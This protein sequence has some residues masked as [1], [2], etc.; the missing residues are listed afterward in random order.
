[1]KTDRVYLDW[2]AT[3]PLRPAARAA[4]IASL[5]VTGNPSSVHAEGRSARRLVEQARAELAALVGGTASG[6]VFTSGGSEANAIALTPGLEG[7]PGHRRG[8]LL[9]SAVEHPSVLSGGRFAHTE[10]EVVGV[11]DQGRLSLAELARRLETHF[12]SGIRPLVSL[13]LANNETGVIQPIAETAELVHGCDGLLH[14]DAVQ[15]A[16][17]FN[18]D[19][20][21]LGADLITLSGHKLGGPQGVGALIRRSEAIHLSDPLIRGGGQERGWRAGT[22]NVAAIAGFGAGAAMARQ[23]LAT[24]PTRLAT[25]R[26]RLEAGLAVI[27]PTTVIFGADAMRLPNTTLFAVPG[28]KAATAIIALDLAGHAVS[29]GSACSSGKVAPSHVLAAMGVEPSLIHGA[30]R[31]SLGYGTV[32]DDIDRFLNAWEKLIKG[33]SN[34]MRDF[35]A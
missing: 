4:M 9:V 21:R 7:A 26:D 14:V 8:R 29:S 19:I 10:I 25:M 3:A 23:E 35:A 28:V 1:M 24:E 27:A 17:R 2:N 16:G 18:I 30:I 33:L 34:P 6:V 5:E 12:R 31:V 32:A 15:A 11:D 20:G 13:M 22:E